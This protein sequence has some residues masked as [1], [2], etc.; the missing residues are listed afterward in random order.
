M[1]DIVVH[2]KAT[3]NLIQ[4]IDQGA[5]LAD[6]CRDATLQCI[7]LC[8]AYQT[9]MSCHCSMGSHSILFVSTSSIGIIRYQFTI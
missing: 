2:G 6:Q 7:D 8:A 1:V 3:S 4:D 9:C 5:L